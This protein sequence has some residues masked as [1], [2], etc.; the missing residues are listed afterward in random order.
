MAEV[1]A[2]KSDIKKKKKRITRMESQCIKTKSQTA[3]ANTILRSDISDYF[4]R[5]RTRFCPMHESTPTPMKTIQISKYKNKTE[6]NVAQT[7]AR[8][9]KFAAHRSTR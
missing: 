6:L 4:P 1:E 8:K 7:N 2:V 3:N 5:L 9:N